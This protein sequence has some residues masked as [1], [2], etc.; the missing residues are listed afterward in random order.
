MELTAIDVHVHPQTE[1]FIKAAGARGA[2][3]AAYF[4]R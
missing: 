3:M 2:Q 4:G 1:E